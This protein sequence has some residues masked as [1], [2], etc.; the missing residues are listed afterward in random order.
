[1]SNNMS[2][3]PYSYEQEK[4]EISIMKR[5]KH[6]S[7]KLLALFLS[8]LMIMTT[9]PLF[10]SAN[11][12]ENITLGNYPDEFKNGTVTAY[13]M[14]AY[15]ATNANTRT[16]TWDKQNNRDFV[17][18]Y[19]PKTIYLDK[20]ESLEEAGYYVKVNWNYGDNGDQNNRI[21][22][23]CYLFGIPNTSNPPEASK[24]MVNSFDNYE[25]NADYYGTKRCGTNAPNDS[26][27]DLNTNAQWQD[28]SQRA[29]VWRSQKGGDNNRNRNNKIFLYGTPKST[30]TSRRYSTAGMGLDY[31]FGGTQD[32]YSSGWKT[33]NEFGKKNMAAS[34]KL[35]GYVE[36]WWDVVV[37][38][39]AA[40]NTAVENANAIKNANTAYTKYATNWSTFT[41]AITSATNIL[42]AREVTQTQIDNAKNALNTAV[43]NLTFKASKDD[44]TSA[45]TRANAVK[46]ATDFE[47][48]YTA[49]SRAALDTAI[50]EAVRYEPT[51]FSAS[52]TAGSNADAQQT[53]MGNL[54]TNIEN[55]INNL[56]NQ[57]KITFNWIDG[58]KVEEKYYAQGT[59]GSAIT[60]P[61]NSA[62]LGKDETGH[63][64]YKWPTFNSVT[65]EATY[66]EVKG[67]TAGHSY[68]DS[69]LTLVAP[70]T[71]QSPAIY[72]G[73]CTV[74]GYHSDAIPRGT[75]DPNAHNFTPLEDGSNVTASTQAENYHTYHTVRC[76]NSGCSVTQDQNCVNAPINT[77]TEHSCQCGICQGTMAH[78]MQQTAEP[79]SATCEHGRINAQRTCTNCGRVTGG[80]EVPNT[81]L[82]HLY[83][84]EWTY[85]SET[86]H[87]RLCTRGCNQP[88][89]DSRYWQ[90]HETTYSYDEAT[91]KHTK[92]CS[93]CSHEWESETCTWD[94]GKVTTQPTCQETGVK[95]YTCTTCK[96]TKTEPI[97]A[98][99]HAYEKE[100]KNGDTLKTAGNCTT[101]AVY[102]YS[103]KFC[104]AC[105][106]ND[107]TLSDAV[108]E[109]LVFEGE[110]VSDNHDFTSGVY[111]HIDGTDTHAQKC[112]RC[113]VTDVA[114]AENCSG[115]AATVCGQKAVCSKCDTAYGSALAHDF[116]NSTTYVQYTETD[117]SGNTIYKHAVKCTR[118][119][120]TDTDNAEYCS[121]GEAT[122]TDQAVCS[123]C[124]NAYGE[125]LGHDFNGA[126]STIDGDGTHHNVGCTRCSA[127]NP[128]D[129]VFT[130]SV[131]VTPPTCTAEGYTTHTC[132]CGNSYVDGTTPSLGHDWTEKDT[133]HK[134]SDA[135]CQK[136]A[137]YYKYCDRCKYYADE[138]TP[139]ASTEVF[140][141]GEMLAH[142]F[143]LLADKSNVINNN[144]GTHSFTCTT[145]DATVAAPAES[146]SV[147]CHYG[148]P[149]TSVTATCTVKGQT[150]ETCD[151]CGYVKT[152]IGAVDAA[153]HVDADG[154][155]TLVKTEAKAATCSAAGN[156]AYW[157]CTAC[158]NVYSDEAGTVITTVDAMVIPETNHTDAD[159]S[160]TLVHHEI[161]PAD[162]ETG[163]PGTKEYWECSVC[164]VKYSDENAANKISDDA[165]LVIPAVH[166]F[167]AVAAKNSTCVEKGNIAY[168]RCDNCHKL[169]KDAAGTIP[170]TI[171]DV[172]LPLAVH[173][174]DQKLADDKY[175]VSA[176]NCSN[177]AVYY[178]SCSV[179]GA[180]SQGTENEDTFDYTEG[181]YASDV[182]SFTGAYAS[183]SDTQHAKLCAYGCGT[184]D[185]VNLEDHTL[186][187]APNGDKATHTV[188]CA[189]CGYEKTDAQCSWDEGVVTTQPTCQSKGV[190]TYTCADC[191]ATK[192]E[193]VEK[194]TDDWTPTGDPVRPTQN[195]DGTW[196]DGYQVYTCMLDGTA[197]GHTKQE[198]LER[199]DYT[200]FE[201]LYNDLV[202][203]RDNNRLV[204]E[205]D[206]KIN[207]ALAEADTLQKD[208]FK[209]TEQTIV[210]EAAE[211]LRLVFDEIKA[212]V[213]DGSLIDPSAN[214]LDFDGIDDALRTYD[215]MIAEGVEVSAED[216][217]RVDAIKVMVEDLRV[218]PY[219][220]VT[221]D[222]QKSIDDWEVEVRAIIGIIGCKHTKVDENTPYEILVEATC[223][224]SGLKAQKCPDCGQ[225]LKP[226]TG[227]PM[228]EHTIDEWKVTTPATCLRA[229]EEEGYCSVCKSTFTRSIPK[230]E[231]EFGEWTV[232][233]ASTCR[234]EGVEKQTCANCGKTNSR[235]IPINPDAHVWTI[236]RAIEPTCTKPG[237]TQGTQCQECGIWKVTPT[238]VPAIGHVDNDH[239]GYCDICNYDFIG[240]TARCTCICHKTSWLMKLLYK[241][242][243]P[244]WKLFKISIICRCGARHY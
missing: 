118:C 116:E 91:G 193:A 153:N 119:S 217:A 45:I 185:P 210:D 8:V 178:V 211:K 152:T 162:C 122:C 62:I 105:A 192:T 30:F 155:S 214:D 15:S 74:C 75:A 6:T 146:E 150:Q 136:K 198:T 127:V 197:D 126:V 205:A 102:Y 87:A 216:S 13:G 47:T 147:G 148:T 84:G 140:E 107:T 160:S 117:G 26:D 194:L 139:V 72:S 203:L 131:V 143:D 168:W 37:Y 7:K 100:I 175:L 9:V 213:D 202:E 120:V 88:N 94:E 96:G 134:A 226:Y 39:K 132:E 20:S 44:L 67:V 184:T 92:T 89:P 81:K 1:M 159:G 176:A 99:H 199:A 182:H 25:V 206:A 55:A 80:N 58:T 141:S 35:N 172:T 161:V 186:D 48:K 52:T 69:S 93:V 2:F 65:G 112:K 240:A 231:H 130:H 41:N 218:K 77:E 11:W 151:V 222:D 29:I 78:D 209:A 66:T 208:L 187:Y 108:K 190:K 244:L 154:N 191:K 228:T 61:A 34:E 180:S 165:E 121:G 63:W 82:E 106:K 219:E 123:T 21:I 40:L 125:A 235:K 10:A 234:N 170:T 124:K 149:V 167:T 27:T 137:T 73:D 157:T 113:D 50:N 70:A 179:C 201:T 83:E 31:G 239:D 79:Q 110:T 38:D 24:V 32:W 173:T 188:S 101:K 169:Y 236:I 242:I 28:S 212:G 64:N 115:E 46:G 56:K 133:A 51:T 233:R 95:T 196:A 71:C 18:A 129:C 224:Q 17:T 23:A 171:E 19:L 4:E 85:A 237:Y 3:L 200:E 5:F 195:E 86:Q 177:Y 16:L 204:D 36:A 181:G 135:T 144:D 166:S 207:A 225:Y 232:T 54:K 42:K 49:E 59:A 43:S 221:A 12:S 174:Y 215:N 243:L 57:Y 142:N 109:A 164:G 90:D 189:V 103:C 183:V 22:V 68:N 220:T 33:T 238:E 114:N 241:I 111:T 128:V 98:V 145:C 97:S 138:I 156:K 163:T 14:P 229:G 227:I 230:L 158:N 76:I 60:P 104:D 223:T 53:E